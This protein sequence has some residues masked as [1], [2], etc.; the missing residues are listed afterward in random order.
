MPGP[1]WE[2]ALAPTAMAELPRIVMA[3]NGS[4]T[5]RVAIQRFSLGVIGFTCGPL[6]NR[7]YQLIVCWGWQGAGCAAG[8]PL[9]PDGA[10][11]STEDVPAVAGVG[12]A[13]FAAE[14]G[15]LVGVV[16]GVGFCG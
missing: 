15:T 9:A 16:T 6:V 2:C 11:P 3:L 1:Y 14:Q 8:W 7:I 12:L 5:L 4:T 13:P 10:I